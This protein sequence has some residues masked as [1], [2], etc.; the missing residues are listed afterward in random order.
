VCTEG[1]KSSCQ[2]TSPWAFF[3]THRALLGL[4]T[5]ELGRRPLVTL[6]EIEGDLHPVWSGFERL[7]LSPDGSHLLLKHYSNGSSNRLFDVKLGDGIPILR[8]VP[9]VPHPAILGYPEFTRDGRSALITDLYSGAYWIDLLAGTTVRVSDRWGDAQDNFEPCGTNSWVSSG[10]TSSGLPSRFGHLTKD[11]VEEITLGTGSASVSPDQRYVFWHA[12][13]ER[14]VLIDC[15]DIDKRTDVGASLWTPG[16]SPS[17]RHFSL[18]DADGMFRLFAIDDAGS[19]TELWSAPNV[20]T[21]EW[22]EEGDHLTVVSDDSWFSLA[23][24]RN[25]VSSPQELKLV[26]SPQTLE[27]DANGVLAWVTAEDGSSQDLVVADHGGGAK[28]LLEDQ[29][30]ETWLD[31]D[32]TRNR[33]FLQ[34]PVDDREELVVVTFDEAGPHERQ[35]FTYRGDLFVDLASDGSGLVLILN[36]EGVVTTSWLSL[37]SGSEA[38]PAEPIT[39]GEGIYDVTFEPWH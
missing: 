4:P 33:A 30:L 19:I 12:N 10:W 8:P 36:S 29:P 34:R 9:E 32:W 27:N 11:G 13:D 5:A 18:D 1:A 22:S 26:G 15:L 24:S 39:L 3:H 37:P 17:S 35:L 21:S 14:A 7:G 16:W 6:G 25:A 31:A 20:D 38:S 2:A 23:V 28:V